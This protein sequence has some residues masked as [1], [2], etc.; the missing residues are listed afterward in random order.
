[1]APS[2]Q[3]TLFSQIKDSFCLVEILP[4]APAPLTCGDGLA[5]HREPRFC[6]SDY[7]CY[8]S[9]LLGVCSSP[10]TA[11]G[12][13]HSGSETGTQHTHAHTHRHQSPV[14]S[15]DKE[16][17]G[18]PERRNSGVQVLSSAPREVR[19]GPVPGAGV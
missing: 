18:S 13:L 10:E 8:V 1:M 14:F 17:P 19:R 9:Q 15:N 5:G 16:P 2:P 6:D 3:H 4:Q 7:L 12:S 11:V